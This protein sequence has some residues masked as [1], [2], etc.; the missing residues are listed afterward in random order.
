M[1][2]PSPS[3]K[4]SKSKFISRCI[5]SQVMQDEYDENKQRQAICYE[6]W[7]SKDEGQD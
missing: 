7:R 6:Q 5:A 2:L 3:S 1:P 4:E